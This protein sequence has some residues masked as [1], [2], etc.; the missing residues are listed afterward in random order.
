MT[1]N[2][3]KTTHPQLQNLPKNLQLIP[4]E[5]KQLNSVAGGTQTP[6]PDCPDISGELPQ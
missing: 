5:L 6:C 3:Q 2:Q 4:L 1:N